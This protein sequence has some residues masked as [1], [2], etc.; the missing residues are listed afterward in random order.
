MGIT[1]LSMSTASLP[2]VRA[3]MATRTLESC[4]NLARL[5]LAARDAPSARAAVAER[6][7]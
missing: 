2:A 7:T 1:S 6:S 3:A 5:A 4:E